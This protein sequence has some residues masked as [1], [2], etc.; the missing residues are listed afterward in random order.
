MK[1][2]SKQQLLA[3]SEAAVLMALAVVLDY[4]CKLI[5]FQFPYGGGISVSVLPLIYFTFRRGTK[6]GLGAGVVFSALQIITGWYPPPAGTWWAL[7]LCILL[8][9]LLAFA[10]LGLADL[11]AKPFGS[12]RLTGYGVGAVAVCLLRFLCSF[13]SG[14]IL[15]DAYC[16]EGM[17]VWLY[18]LLY[19]GGYMLPNAVLTGILAVLL[20]RAMDP[21]TLR[22]MKKAVSVLK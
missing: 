14:V 15:W 22:P 8:D 9:Y 12:H 20:C 6:W 18:S 5:P 21:H 17:N 13:L 10:L 19:N 4:L 2:K 16:P 11:F 1:T 3:L 7:I